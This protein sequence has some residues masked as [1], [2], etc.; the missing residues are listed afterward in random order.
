MHPP[1]AGFSPHPL[2]DITQELHR[3]EHCPHPQPIRWSPGGTS[4]REETSKR[5]LQPSVMQ[6]KSCHLIEERQS[7]SLQLAVV[8]AS[9]VAEST[10]SENGAYPRDPDWQRIRTIFEHLYIEED[11]TLKETMAEL[12]LKHD[13]RATEQMFK[14]QIRHWGLDKN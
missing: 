4:K 1:S 6:P 2:V 12:R 9:R 11:K 3:Q 10:N 13:F 5:D 14:K 8:P 7:V